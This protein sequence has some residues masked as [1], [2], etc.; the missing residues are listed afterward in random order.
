MSGSKKR[1]Q[2]KHSRGRPVKN[3]IKP[4]DATL[5]EIAQAICPNADRELARKL[6]IKKTEFV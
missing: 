4:I 5:K 1:L 6:R 2:P 3:I